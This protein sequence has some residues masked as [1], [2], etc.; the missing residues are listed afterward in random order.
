V[1][2]LSARDNVI[3]N[4]AL[5][6]LSPR[7]AER[8]YEEI[9]EFAGLADFAELS[10]R[11]YSSG[12]IVRLGFAVTVTIEANVLLIDEVL[13]VGDAE[14]QERCLDVL[15]RRRREGTTILLVS[16]SME[17][18]AHNC[19]RAI[20]IEGGRVGADGDPA[21]VGRSYA[22]VMRAH[23]RLRSDSASAIVGGHA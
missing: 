1:P 23:A 22:D 14:F 11:N 17:K 21:E 12:M 16:H 8:R 4:G 6:G 13:A 5:L 18:V 3:L 20:L 9:L 10:L 15:G 7:E 2:D 19:D